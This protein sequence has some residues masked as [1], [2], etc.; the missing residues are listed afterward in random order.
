MNKGNLTERERLGL[1]LENIMKAELKSLGFTHLEH[2]GLESYK[3]E[4]NEA[5]HGVDFKIY[6]EHGNLAI[7][8][9]CKH[10][11]TLDRKY[12]KDIAQTEVIDRFEGLD[13]K[14]NILVISNFDVYD[15][16]AQESIL[17][18][19]IHVFEIGKLL[20][21]KIFKSREFFILRSRLDRFFEDIETEHSERQK[22]DQQLIDQYLKNHNPYLKD[23]HK[24]QPQ[25]IC[26]VSNVDYSSYY[27]IVNT[28]KQT[29]YDTHLGVDSQKLIEK[30]EKTEIP[31]EEIETAMTE[32]SLNLD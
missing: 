28:V 11:R 2:T 30:V 5:R 26:C 8:I 20:G 6:G 12:S 15:K 16:Q 19:G 7:A 31:I 29:T 9:E 4:K 21:Y 1:T 10:L 27:D 22:R 32:I 3:H 14:F 25:P 13:T 17:N 18:H 23:Q 24:V